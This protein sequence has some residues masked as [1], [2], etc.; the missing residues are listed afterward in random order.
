MGMI[1]LGGAIMNSAE[2]HPFGDPGPTAEEVCQQLERILSSGE[3]HSSERGRRFLQFII[4]ETLAGRSEFLKAFTIA[5]D[6]FGREVSFDAQNDP[7]VRIEAGRIRRRLERYYLVAGQTDPVTITVPKGGY[8]PRFEYSHRPEVPASLA[9]SPDAVQDVE[10]VD[11]ERPF[12][13][14]GRSKLL[15]ALVAG[16]FLVIAAALYSF[17]APE[18]SVSGGAIPGTS[19][20]EASAPKVVVEVFGNGRPVDTTFDIAHGLRD[21]V[22]GQLAK[23][24]DVV[25]IVDPSRAEGAAGYALQGNIQLDGE[26]LRSVA[27]L[28]R[29]FDGAVIW[30]NNYDADLRAQSKLEIQSDVAEQIAIAVAQPYGA[31]FQADTDTIARQ[32]QS[33]NWDAYACT[34]AYYSYRR[35]MSAQSHNTARDCLQR[36]TQR[37]PKSATS[38]ALLSLTYLD[39]M[40]FHYKLGTSSS[41]QPLELATSAAERAAALAPNNARVLQALMLVSFFK[42]DIDKALQAGAAAYAINPNDTEV[43]GE[44][45]LRLAMSGKWQS[46]C[47]LVS[48][49]V[50]KN[51]GP[52]GYYE[53]GMALCALMRNDIRAAELW[54][55]MSDLDYNP[56]HRLVLLSILGAAGKPADAKQEQDWLVAHAPELMNNIRREVSLRLQRPEDQDSFFS[57]LRALGIAIEPPQP[58]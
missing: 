36:A 28:V 58:E 12:P 53:V 4:S 24:D 46:G 40:R 14:P 45:G 21:E 55:R 51:A 38:W 44:Y 50:N 42:E 43:A 10:A 49:A 57:G 41:V 30:A 34:L 54:S 17:L 18:R 15:I 11:H 8:V 13:G 16:T 22:I 23:F 19:P 25:V 7:V 32:P 47:E 48:G 33:G 52:K 39:E 56:M 20:T 37:F 2:V 9:P 5:N 27:R 3:F 26:R 31:I 6:V 1:L 29:Q 35:S